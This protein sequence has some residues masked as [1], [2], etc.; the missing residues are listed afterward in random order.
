VEKLEDELL[1]LRSALQTKGLIDAV[2]SN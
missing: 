2:T 1:F